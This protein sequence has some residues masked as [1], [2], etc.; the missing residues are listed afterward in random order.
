M[1][2]DAMHRL[3]LVW[4]GNLTTGDLEAALAT[5]AAQHVQID[6]MPLRYDVRTRC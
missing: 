5:A 1:C 4:D 6:V 3:L 2:N